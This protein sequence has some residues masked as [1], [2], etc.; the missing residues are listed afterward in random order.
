MSNTQT[1]AKNLLIAQTAI[2]FGM[3]VLYVLFLTMPRFMGGADSH[4]LTIVLLYSSVL[5]MLVSVGLSIYNLLGKFLPK[6]FKKQQTDAEK[7]VLMSAAIGTGSL[8]FLLLLISYMVLPHGRRAVIGGTTVR[9]KP[10]QRTWGL[11][12]LRGNALRNL[13]KG[14]FDLSKIDSDARNQTIRLLDPR[15]LE[16]E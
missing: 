13:L 2:P 9:F 3:L 7:K 14:K 4:L 12:Q 16:L 8:S 11:G 5:A 1:N 6:I 15:L 10:D